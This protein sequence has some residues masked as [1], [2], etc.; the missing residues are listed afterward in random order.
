MF[1]VE[2]SLDNQRLR[3]VKVT[4]NFNLR[5]LIFHYI[6]KYIYKFGI[7]VDVWLALG[8]QCGGG[9]PGI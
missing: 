1:E 3:K 9:E 8:Q 7:C 6:Y 5:T 2:A 4:T